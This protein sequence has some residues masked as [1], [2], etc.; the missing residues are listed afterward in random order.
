MCKGCKY[1]FILKHHEVESMTMQY[2]PGEP[3]LL[4]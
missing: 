4:F 3:K 1:F 2:R